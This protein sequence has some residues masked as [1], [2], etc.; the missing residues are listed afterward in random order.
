MAEIVCQSSDPHFAQLLNRLREGK[1]T[2]EDID[3]IKALTN[4]GTSNWSADHTKL[5]IT[6]VLV[7]NENDGYLKKLKDKGETIFTTYSKDSITDRDTGVHKINIDGNFPI[8]Y[9]GNLA[10]HLKI[11]VGAKVML[12]VN[13]DTR[14]WLIYGS[15]VAVMYMNNAAT[16]Q[17][18]KGIIYV[19]FD[20][21][22]VGNSCK[23]NWLH[24]VFEQYVP[25]SVSTN[26]FSF[27]R[28]TWL[29]VDKR[30]QF[31]LILAH[32]ITIHKSQGSA[33]DYMA[34]N[35]D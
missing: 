29:I 32:A 5:C 1:H 28:G 18:A 35:L 27:K 22:N 19:K 34:G 24:G 33:V 20:D 15:I 6:N 7:N 3:D 31:P 12:T 16:N 17:V 25:I 14:D 30:K 8:I 13:M 10:K 4:T 23:D 11:C 26:R 9:T 21:E 2:Q